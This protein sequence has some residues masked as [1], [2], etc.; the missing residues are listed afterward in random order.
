[1]E[2]PKRTTEDLTDSTILASKRTKK[3]LKECNPFS[4]STLDNVSAKV[5][6]IS[7]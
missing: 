1:M 5:F 6:A 7:I 2:N 4:S 3:E